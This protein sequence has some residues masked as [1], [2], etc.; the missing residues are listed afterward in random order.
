MWPDVMLRASPGIWAHRPTFIIDIIMNIIMMCF[1]CYDK[2]GL[3]LIRWL[4][5]RSPLPDAAVPYMMNTA[6]VQSRLVS[7]GWTDRFL[8]ISI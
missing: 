7:A 6:G 3:N 4:S 5:K 2:D 8:L 1:A